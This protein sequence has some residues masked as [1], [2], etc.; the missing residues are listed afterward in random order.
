MSKRSI[1]LILYISVFVFFA[2]PY[3]I[4][5]FNLAKAYTEISLFENKQQNYIENQKS[6]FQKKFERTFPNDKFVFEDLYNIK[7]AT[8]YSDTVISFFIYSNT[9]SKKSINFSYINC[10]NLKAE[11]QATKNIADRKFELVLNYLE[12]KYGTSVREIVSN[13]NRNKF[14]TFVDSQN[15]GE[16]FNNNTYVLNNDAMYELNQ[17]F[18]E[19][20][21]NEEIVKQNNKSILYRYN[22]EIIKIK[23]GLNFSEQNLLD[24]YLSTSPPIN[25]INQRFN[26]SGSHLGN[27][28]YTILSKSIDMQ[29]INNAL[30]TIYNNLYTNS[31]LRNG[32]MPYDYCY[33]SQN[34]GP[35]SIKINSGSSDVLI[36]VKNIN[37]KVIRHVYVLASNSFTLRVPNGKYH[38]YFYYGNGWNPKKIMGETFCGILKGGFINNEFTSKDPDVIKLNYSNLTYTL[39]KHKGGNFDPENCSKLDAF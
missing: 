6:N 39:S 15:C 25:D 3:T 33:G 34:N 21:I 27:F 5:L 23:K 37:N 16:F 12:K 30:N 17:L 29:R 28:D 35:S 13:I 4:H 38:V 18:K 36:T 11:S 2:I 32:E 14:F 8:S 26:F 10:L 19:Y 9:L 31:S 20:A 1:I 7:T 22:E 24:K